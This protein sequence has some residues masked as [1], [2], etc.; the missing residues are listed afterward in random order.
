MKDGDVDQP[1]IYNGISNM[2]DMLSAEGLQP[3]RWSMSGR[4]RY[5]AQFAPVDTNFDF[6]QRQNILS[7]PRTAHCDE[8]IESETI[9]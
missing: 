6:L 2:R 1:V 4:C 9:Q 3:K 5:L 8:R 7:K